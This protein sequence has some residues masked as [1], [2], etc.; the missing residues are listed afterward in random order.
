MDTLVTCCARSF[1][2]RVALIGIDY[3]H[4][5]VDR[6]LAKPLVL[7]DHVKVQELT[8]REIRAWHKLISEEVSVYSANK[9]M[10]FLK[11]A[12]EL[13]AEDHEFRPPAMP[14]GLQRQ[15]DKAR[16]AVLTP[17]Q[18]AMVLAAAREDLDKGL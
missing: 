10:M 4:T 8:T 6:L 3:C 9:A 7:L 1:F 13:A 17:D 5:I 14:T 16:K 12:L 2:S 15:R 11:A 18:V